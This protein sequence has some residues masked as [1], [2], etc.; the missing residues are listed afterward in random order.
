MSVRKAPT[1]ITT[2][3]RFI[4]AHCDKFS[5]QVMCRILGVARAGYYEKANA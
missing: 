2:A 1:K 5:I 4:E 3:H